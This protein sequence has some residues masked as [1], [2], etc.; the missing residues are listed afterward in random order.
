MARYV[1]RD[2]RIL[3][4]SIHSYNVQAIEDHSNEYDDFTLYKLR[5]F[6]GSSTLAIGVGLDDDKYYIVFRRVR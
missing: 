1:R 4:I 6:L 5:S 3:A 2:F